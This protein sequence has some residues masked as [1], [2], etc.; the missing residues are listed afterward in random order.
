LERLAAAEVCASSDFAVKVTRFLQRK[1]ERATELVEKAQRAADSGKA[2][3][4]KGQ[5]RRLS[6]LLSGVERR[7]RALVEEGEIPA[8][9]AAEVEDAA[10]GMKAFAASLSL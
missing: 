6:K 3:R 10:A 7:S 2:R 8:E 1:V 5:L 4:M 9:C